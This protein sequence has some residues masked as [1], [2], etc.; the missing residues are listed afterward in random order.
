[1][2]LGTVAGSCTYALLSLTGMTMQDVRYWS[3]KWQDARKYHY[4]ELL[5]SDENKERQKLLNERDQMLESEKDLHSFSVEKKDNTI[6]SKQDNTSETKQS[7][8]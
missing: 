2:V 6:E 1:M 4:Q 7:N 5:V 8:T 3:N